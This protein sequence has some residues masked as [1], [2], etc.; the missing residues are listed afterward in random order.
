MTPPVSRLGVALS[1]IYV[2]V[3]AAL[4]YSQG[5]FGESF[6]AIILGL[7]LSLVFASF[8]FGNVSGFFVYVLVLLPIIFN[9][10]LLY[11]IGYCIGFI[12]RR[13]KA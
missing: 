3:C 8:E 9:T 6:I 2:I 4:I 12:G 1:A 7:P 5:L 11:W 10:F 13:S